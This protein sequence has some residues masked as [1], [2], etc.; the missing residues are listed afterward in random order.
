[1]LTALND[2]VK[3]L[4]EKYR[5]HF[6]KTHSLYTS[7]NLIAD[8]RFGYAQECAKDGDFQ[9]ASE[10]YEQTLELVPNFAPAWFELGKAYVALNRK[11]AGDAFAHY[12]QLDSHDQL[13]AGLY[14]SSSMS[15]A[16]V[17]TLFDNYAHKFDTHLV[18]SLHYSGPKMMHDSITA[19]C[20]TSN[21]PLQFDTIT[22]VGCGT[23]LSGAQ[24]IGNARRLI[25]CDLSPEMIKVAR[26]K[27]IYHDLLVTDAITCLNQYQSDLVLAIDVL[28]YIGNLLSLFLAI[29]SS[30]K[31]NG[32]V[33]LSLQHH[34]GEGFILGY[35]MRFAHSISYIENTAKLC[36]LRVSYTKMATMRQDRGADVA[37]L[38]VILEHMY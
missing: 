8:R 1:M 36:S 19:F 3:T 22:D 25:G 10:L 18:D 17:T 37:G 33:A 13:G 31:L 23:G 6:L 14:L 16:Y 11:E 24:F 32:L 20:A 15:T 38:I 9:T 28:V 4:I 12:L 2:L 30:L 34:A 27:N 29:K 21:R 35:D 5:L 26:A 7:H